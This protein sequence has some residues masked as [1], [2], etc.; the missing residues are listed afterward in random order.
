MDKEQTQ[1]R[2]SKI[3]DQTMGNCIS[4]QYVVLQKWMDFP[5]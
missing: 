3:L 5:F 4:H 2:I 1:G